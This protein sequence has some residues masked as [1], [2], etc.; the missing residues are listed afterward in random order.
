MT[1]LMVAFFKSGLK[2]VQT[3]K[4]L[5]DLESYGIIIVYDRIL[6]HKRPGGGYEII[7]ED[8][9]V[10]YTAM[11]GGLQGVL[12][13]PVGFIA[14]AFAGSAV[15]T[16]AAINHYHFAGAFIAEL[17]E[18]MA[19]DTVSIIVETDALTEEFTDV[20]VRSFDAIVVKTNV[21]FPPGNCFSSKIQ[22]NQQ[23]I[24]AASMELKK[25][26]NRLLIQAQLKT[27]K[28]S[29]LELLA[30]FEMGYSGKAVAVVPR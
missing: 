15:E 19:A 29:R 11:A 6:I 28:T 25:G 24:E 8:F 16:M 17:V 20:Y 1:Q 9:T 13:G 7:E 10:Q 26:K 12:T 30:G 21:D 22:K 5:H 23:A 2:A 3:I 18:K 27:L 14:G 4:K